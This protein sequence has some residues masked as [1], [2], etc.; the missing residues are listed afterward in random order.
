MNCPYLKKECPFEHMFIDEGWNC[1]GCDFNP[2]KIENK[3]G[4]LWIPLTAIIL[5]LILIL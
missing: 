1:Y 3:G 5:L 2:N 4:C